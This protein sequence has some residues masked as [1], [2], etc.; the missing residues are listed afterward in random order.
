[1]CNGGILKVC[2][3]L[4]S[5]KVYIRLQMLRKNGGRKIEAEY[6]GSDVKRSAD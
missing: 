6:G 5:K 3:I 1:M 2:V 4:D